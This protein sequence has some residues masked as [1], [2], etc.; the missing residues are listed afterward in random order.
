MQPFFVLATQNPIEQEGTYP[1]PEAQ[2]DRFMF[3][4]DVPFLNRAELNEVVR[5]TTLTRVVDVPKIMDGARIL[6]LRGIL[7]KVVVADPLRDYAVRLVLATHPTAT[8]AGETV[9]RYVKW[10]ASPRAVQALIRGSRVRALAEG[11]AH[12]AFDDIRRFV[13][14]VLGHRVLLNYDGL[15]ETVSV[16]DLV[17]ELTRLVPEEAAA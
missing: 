5:R 16:P 9:R 1:L 6:E 11:R 17:A 10:G 12:V 2:L 7:E 3:K 4:L 14:D 8:E 15:A 13:P